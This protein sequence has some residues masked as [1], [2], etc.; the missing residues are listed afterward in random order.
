M[1]DQR[2]PRRPGSPSARLGLMLP[3]AAAVLT[4]LATGRMQDDA[5]MEMA[6]EMDGGMAMSMSDDVEFSPAELDFFESKVRPLLIGACSACHSDNGS[7]IRAGF[8]IDTRDAMLIG[9]DT[10]PGIV[11]GHPDASLLIQAVRYDDPGLQMPP[12]GAL[13][14]DEIATLERWVEMGAPMPAPRRSGVDGGVAPGTEGRWSADDIEAGRDHWAYR[15]VAAPIVPDVADAAWPRTDVDRFVLANLEARGLHPVED[16]SRETWL[17][18]VTFDLVGLPPTLA[19]IDAYL[20]DESAEPEARV[21]D[22]LLASPAFGERWGRHWLDVARY[23]ESSGKENNVAYPHA[24]R[25]RDWVV[26]AFNTDVPYDRFVTMQLAGDLL[27]ARTE[28]QEAE[29]LIATGYLAIGPKGHNTQGRAQF[30]LDLVDEQ[31]DVIGQ[32]LL[33]TTVSCARCHDHK[34]DPIPQVDYYAMAGILGSTETRFGTIESPGNRQAAELIEI[35]AGAEL[36]DG[37][38]F[39]ELARTIVDGIRNRAQRQVDAAEDARASLRAQGVRG[40][41][42]G[43][44]DDVRQILQRARQSEGLVRVAD[45]LL[46]RFDDQGRPTIDN[47]VCMGVVESDPRDAPFLERGE[48]DGRGDPVRRG[49]PQVL[50]SSWSP[51][52][53]SGSGRLELAEWI[54]DARHPLTARV[55]ANR[56]WSHLFGSGIVPTPDNFGLSGRPP[57]NPALLDH[58]ASRLVALDW[59]TKALI[60]ELVLSRTYRLASTHDRDN[61]EIDPDIVHL[62]RMPER[63]LEAEAIRDAMLAVAGVLD[64][65]PPIGSAAAILE[66]TIRDGQTTRLIDAVLEQYRNNRSIYQPIIRG[67]VPEALAVFDFPEPDFVVGDRDETNVATQALYL[68]NAEET[69][70]LADAFAGRVLAGGRDFQSRVERAFR[71]AFGRE[72]SNGE[73]RACRSFLNDFDEAWTD[74]QR[75][76]ARSESPQERRRRMIAQRIRERSAG[77]GFQNARPA[78]PDPEREAWT[79]LCQTLLQSSEFRTLD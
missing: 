37:P 13:S 79:A 2:D 50:T 65:T 58:L 61:A 68:M 6:D 45:S 64:P 25:Y 70:R 31:I 20:Q 1:T 77:D 51:S 67:D 24:W 71:Y 38:H 8:K 28:H 27:P 30:T 47:F 73:Y 57:S 10:G 11:P 43:V 46:A 74:D 48:L 7:R 19:E 32:G 34:F 26:S 44:P 56:I 18:R 78:P 53:G 35:P 36:P 5:M 42:E 12:R 15:P 76:R 14:R 3:L 16:A 9:G 33:A 66:G 72:P 63:R 40:M 75:D 39:P 54:T 69:R 4:G 21:V 52:I 55:W 60:R 29:N 41:R 23:A 22:R 17:R 59:S 62:W 49:F